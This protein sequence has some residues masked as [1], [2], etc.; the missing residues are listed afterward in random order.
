MAFTT[1][2]GVLTPEQD[3]TDGK[4]QVSTTLSS[5]T[6]GNMIVTAKVS[7]NTEDVG[8]SA[9]ATFIIPR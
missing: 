9:T 2:G 3:K 8:K 5:Q 1:T 6:E 7:N 4:G